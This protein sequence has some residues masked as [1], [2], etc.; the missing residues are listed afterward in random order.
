MK[1]AALALLLSATSAAAFPVTVQSC[2]REVTFDEASA[3]H[4]GIWVMA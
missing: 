3:S 2:D 4:A 1:P